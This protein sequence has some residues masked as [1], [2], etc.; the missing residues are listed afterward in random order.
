MTIKFSLESEL[1]GPVRR[2]LLASGMHDIQEELPFYDYRLDVYGYSRIKNVTCAVELKLTKWRRALEQA[3]I[4]QLCADYVCIA[5]PVSS[6]SLVKMDLLRQ[7]GIGLIAVHS[8]RRC[9]NLLMPL[10]SK[11]VV[12]SYKAFYIDLMN[13]RIAQ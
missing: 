11:V 3:I 13:G 1:L 8:Q 7:H 12:P 9:V 2:H 4:Y 10:Q 6:C 5:L